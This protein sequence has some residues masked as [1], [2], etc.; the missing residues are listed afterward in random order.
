VTVHIRLGD[1]GHSWEVR[2]TE[3]GARVRKGVT[4]RTPDVTIG[5]DSETWLRLRQGELSGIEAFSQ[6]QLYVRGNLD[7]AVAFE[8]L[9]R[10]PNGRDPLLRVRDVEVGRLKVSTLTMGEGPDVLL[11]HGLGGTRASFMDTAA[12]LS[13]EYRVHAVDLPGFGASS[14]HAIARYDAGFFADAMF[15]LMD[16]LD[17]DRARVVGNSMGGKIGIEMGLRRPERVVALGLLCPAVG[18]VKRDFH[19]LVRVLRP[20][21]GVLPH[22][23]SRKTIG[24]MV[25]SLF[26][27]PDALDPSVADVVVD[28][29]QRTYRSAAARVAFLAS[30]RNIYLNK[31]FGRGGYYPRLSTLKTPSLFVWGSHDILIP[32]SLK[33]YVEEWLPSAEQIVLNRCGH[34]PQIERPAQTN[35]LLLRFFRRAD[36]LAPTQAPAQRSLRAA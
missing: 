8:G 24:S 22:G 7:V 15:G 27:D 28:D 12:T 3:H 4:R 2:A 20:E 1:I 11:I 34:V 9:F 21:F 33:R 23:F 16:A 6:R 35:G 31:P 13:R 29:F 19:P 10:L 32:A 17:I 36:A 26:A 14:K 25:A 5:T 30:A 18:F